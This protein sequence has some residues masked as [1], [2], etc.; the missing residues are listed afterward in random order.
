[1]A[2]GANLSSVGVQHSGHARVVPSLLRQINARRIMD[3]L[4]QEGP[5]SRAE[6]VRRTSISAPTMSRLMES[7]EL[8]G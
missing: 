3:L 1:M 4:W 5:V 8:P 2:A 7:L 6:L